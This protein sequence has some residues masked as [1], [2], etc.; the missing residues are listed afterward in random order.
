[1]SKC[2]CARDP[3]AIFVAAVAAG[4][5]HF[6]FYYP[7]CFSILL[8]YLYAKMCAFSSNFLNDFLF[9][10]LFLFCPSPK[11][12]LL[13]CFTVNILL[14]CKKKIMI[15]ASFKQKILTTHTYIYRYIQNVFLCIYQVLEGHMKETWLKW[16][17]LYKGLDRP[18]YELSIAICA[19]NTLCSF[20][21]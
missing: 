5:L 1:M 9:Y 15:L 19:C 17:C 6:Q 11:A 21:L 18:R 13:R 14:N 8:F 10:I 7:V 12:F 4:L 2:L 3:N 16:Q 20:V